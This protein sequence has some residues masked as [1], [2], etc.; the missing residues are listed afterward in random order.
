MLL[1]PDEVTEEQRNTDKTD[2]SGRMSKMEREEIEKGIDPNS[3]NFS[4]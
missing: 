4:G 1:K 3:A 2:D